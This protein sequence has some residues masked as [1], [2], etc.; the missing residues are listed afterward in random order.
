L[1]QGSGAPK[2][3]VDGI[4]VGNSYRV[5]KTGLT[6]LPPVPQ[7]TA[8]PVCAGETTTFADASSTVEAN[9]TYAWDVNGD[10]VTDYTTKGSITHKYTAA[11]TYNVKLTITQGACSQQYTQAVTVREL[12]TASISGTP[13]ICAGNTASLP[14]HLTGTA[15]WTLTYSADGDTAPTTV[16]I[17]ETDVVQGVY[18]LVVNPTATHTYTLLGVQDNNCTGATP[19]GTATVTVNTK[20]VLTVPTLPAVDAV[21]G[22]RGASVSFAATATGSTPAP[23]VTYSITRNGSTTAI[24]SPYVF[25]LGTTVVTATAVNDC[26]TTSETFPVTVQTP[27]LVR[28]LHQNADGIVGNNAIKPNL[29]LVNNSTAAIPYAEMSVRYWL[30]AEEYAP[31]TATIDYAQLGAAGVKAKYVALSQPAEGAFGYIEYTFTA[32]GNLPVGGNSGAIQSRIAKQTQTNFNEAD[33]YSYATSATYQQ[34]NR[35]TVY[36]NGVL[37]SGI[38]PALITAKPSVQVWT[39]NKERK[40]TSNTIST[41]LQVRNVGS[42]PLA[43]QDLTVRYW[44]SPEG[45]QQLNSFIDYAQLGNSNVSFTFGQAGDQKYAELHFAAS[46]GSLA[47]LSST[48]NV[49]YRITKA[50]WSNFNLANDFS[51]LPFGAM[52]ENNHVT[53]YLQGERIYGQEPAGAAVASR[54]A[55]PTPTASQE[56]RSSVLGDTGLRSYPN[57]FSGSTTL[58]FAL[59]KPGAYQ[60]EVYDVKGRLVQRLQAGQAQEGQLVRVS[61]QAGTAAPGLYMARLTTATGVQTLKL[62][63]E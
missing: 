32:A 11:G 6:C 1:R 2:V 58:E 40:T 28:V 26:G 59:A 19:S 24:T 57:P 47:P 60:L 4:R 7:F 51:Y 10:D 42:Q 43:Y 34:N 54:G 5:V 49:Q 29:Q 8:A 27:M 62:V 56:Q 31:I 35:I 33:D 15:P 46:L 18:Q 53:V 52:S 39:E 55:Q 20:P 3:V 63:V 17:V 37:I 48:G 9:A 50:D 38:E 61:W 41:Y 22:V 45:T 44:F 36:R 30:T 25:P 23:A 21:A 14:V 12:P 13:T 16:S